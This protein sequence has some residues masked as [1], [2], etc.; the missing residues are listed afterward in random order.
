[1]GTYRELSPDTITDCETIQTLKENYQ[2]STPTPNVWTLNAGGI[3]PSGQPGSDLAGCHIKFNSG[4]YE[5]TK[6]NIND[7]LATYTPPTPAPT[8]FTFP[9]FIYKDE[10][11]SISVNLPLT[12]GVNGSGG[13]QMLGNKQAFAQ[14]IHMPTGPQGE[15]T[16][17][18]GS[19]VGEDD[20]T[21]TSANA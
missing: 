4:T 2:M 19:G 3:T 17:Q 16:A 14:H 13:W 15:Y 5:F 1:L 12:S 7:I 20:P 11:W 9:D 21:A 18:A 8:S 10:R 6:P